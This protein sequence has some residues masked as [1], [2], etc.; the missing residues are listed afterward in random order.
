MKER[1]RHRENDKDMSNTQEGRAHGEQSEAWNPIISLRSLGPP[2]PST[3]L[4]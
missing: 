2:G 1:L 4:W 3:S